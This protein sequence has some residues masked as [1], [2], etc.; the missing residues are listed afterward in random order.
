M[1]WQKHYQLNPRKRWL[2]PEQRVQLDDLV[3]Q[4]IA[5]TYANWK[6]TGRP[7]P[8]LTTTLLAYDVAENRRFGDMHLLRPNRRRTLVDASL[9]RLQAKGLVQSSLC[10]GERGDEV[11]C[12]EPV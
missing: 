10:G 4:I 6:G 7:E 12:W 1:N 5:D 8:K 2:S 3:Y 9:R 11:H